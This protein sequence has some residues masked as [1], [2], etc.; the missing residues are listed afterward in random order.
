M[1]DPPAPAGAPDAATDRS[2]SAGAPGHGGARHRD[3]SVAVAAC[4]AGAGLALLAVSRIWVR[5]TVVRPAP[6]PPLHATHTGSGLAPWLPALALVALAGSGALLATR[7]AA[8]YLVGALLV[9][10]G[11]GLAAGT[12]GALPASGRLDPAWPVVTV[13]GGLLVAAAGVLTVV[14]GRSWPG[15]SARYER[16]PTT[17][18]GET[19][20]GVQV[21]EALDRGDDPTR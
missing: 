20:T 14:R 8:R 13:L 16:R 6:L 3:R 18:T 2:A 4:A 17:G 7:G 10:A 21:W 19:A 12:A 9:V 1:S 11:A 5:E 15:M